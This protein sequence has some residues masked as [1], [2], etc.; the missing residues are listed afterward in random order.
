M[1]MC[2]H[3]DMHILDYVDDSL[4]LSVPRDCIVFMITFSCSE[5][6][7]IEA[8]RLQGGRPGSGS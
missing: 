8:G 3:Q 6:H 7:D 2:I 5:G 1:R 4:D